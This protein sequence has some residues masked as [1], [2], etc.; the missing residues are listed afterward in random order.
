MN[1]TKV[2]QVL[3]ACEAGSV[4]PQ[5]STYFL[6]KL[7]TGLVMYRLDGAAPRPAGGDRGRRTDDRDDEITADTLRAGRVRI[8]QPARGR[9][10][11][12]GPGAAR[13]VSCRRR[14]AGF[15]TSAAAPGAL[16]FLLLARDPA[17][18]RRR[19]RA[20][21]AAGGAGGAR[22]R[23]ERLAAAA[24]DRRRRRAE[25]QLRA[26]GWAQRRSIWSR[27]TRRTGRWRGSRRPPDDERA[28]A[29][30]EIALA[31]AEW[32]ACAARAVRPGGR[33]AAIFPAER[34]ADLLA[35]LRARDL[36]PVRFRSV[37]PARG[38][39]RV[40][41][42]RRGGARGGRRAARRR[43]AA[44]ATCR[45]A[46]ATRR[47]CGA[48]STKSSGC[49]IAP[50]GACCLQRRSG[51]WGAAAVDGDD[52]ATGTAGSGGHGAARRAR[53]ERPARPERRAAGGQ[54]IGSS[55]C[56]L[57]TPDDVWNADVSG[58]PVDATNTSKMNAL[59]GAVNIH[60]DFGPG[61]GIPINVVPAEP[62]GVPIMFDAYADESDPGPYPFPGPANVR[63]EGPTTRRAATATATSSSCSRGRAWPTKATPASTTPT[64]GTARTA[65]TGI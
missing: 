25:R 12:P 6:P 41:R 26:I 40:A 42:A 2:E 22:A 47:R 59:I 5:K 33:V 8:F 10:H 50:C 16:S 60:P 37:H 51:W 3:A 4:L 30:Q 18:T 55:G 52:G 44:G 62:A 11:E 49:T 15:S 21:A 54:V 61:F 7:A 56:P 31:L 19:R 20:A 45:T 29:H 28:L 58:K 63:V 9:A 64:A 39:A 27:P 13:R 48:C 65:R 35:E 46:R 24:R 14:T 53:R 34:A 32:V 43:A 36:D 17:A 57:F 23:R 38:R 1:A